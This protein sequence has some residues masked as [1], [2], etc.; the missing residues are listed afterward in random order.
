MKPQLDQQF[1]LM[2]TR[3]GYS[4]WAFALATITI[5]LSGFG[6]DRNGPG[7]AHATETYAKDSAASSTGIHERV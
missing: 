1:R 3:T 5:I 6:M 2:F 7:N 4:G